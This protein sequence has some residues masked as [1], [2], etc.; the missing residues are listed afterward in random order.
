VNSAQS[1][2]LPVGSQLNFGAQNG[3][4]WQLVDDA[5]PRSLLLADTPDT[6]TLPLT[7]YLFLPDDEQPQLV[8]NYSSPRRSWLYHPITRGDEEL[9]E[10][11]LT[12]GQR[13]EVD[14]RA[15]RVF[16]A[17]SANSTE[18][19][20]LSGQRL[21]DFQFLF[22]L[23]LD[24]EITRLRLRRQGRDI[25]LGE[26]SHHYLLM[27]LARHRAE[28]S[29]AGL[30]QK[31]QGWVDTELLARELGVDVSHLNILIFRARKQIAEKL[32][33]S[34]DSEQLVERRKGQVRFG[35]PHFTI[36]KG[37]TATHQMLRSP[38]ES[39]RQDDV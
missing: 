39:A 33:P 36:Y 10:H 35:C 17:E 19:M 13:L 28:E 31:C 1:T 16:L 7:S 30:D 23:S 29:V 15:W 2:E 4:T 8:V 12:H 37:E 25:D 11:A 22:D 6:A 18:L 24:E 32:P 34:I 14:G 3:P 9:P 21:D 20:P 27:H 26:R 5:P 38:M